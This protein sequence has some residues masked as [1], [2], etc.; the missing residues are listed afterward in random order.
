MCKALRTAIS[1]VVFFDRTLDMMALRVVL[2]T[3]SAIVEYLKVRR[4]FN[5]QGPVNFGL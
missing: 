2:S 4:Y 1:G 5:A 3:W